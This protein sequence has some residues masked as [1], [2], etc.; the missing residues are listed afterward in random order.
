[1]TMQE[2]DRVDLPAGTAVALQPG[3]YHI[4][5]L[6]LAEPLTLGETIEV[7]LQFENAGEQT[8]EVPVRDTAP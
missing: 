3:G 5:L 2:V 8:V 6:G 7:T 4:M 1:M